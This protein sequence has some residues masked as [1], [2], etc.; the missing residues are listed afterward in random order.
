MNILDIRFSNSQSIGKG[1]APCWAERYGLDEGDALRL[2]R[3][4]I[5]R[6]SPRGLRGVELL[7]FCRDVIALG[8][9]TYDD[10]ERSVDFH[11]AVAISLRERSTR[12]PRTQEELRLVTS[13]MLNS[14]L[15][16][17]KLRHIS[18]SDCLGVLRELFATPHQF[19]KGRAILHS[20]FACGIKHGWCSANPVDAIL[21]PELHEVEVQPLPWEQLLSLLRMAQ[22]P[23]HLPCMPALG[24]MLWAGVRP[25]EVLRLDWA[26]LDWE[27]SVISL[28]PR[29]TKTGGSRHITMHPALRT[30]LAR[31]ATPPPT[32]GNICPPDWC[33]RW[34]RL[35]RDAGILN[36]QQDTLRHTFASYHLK[37][38]HD[39]GRLQEEMGHRSSRLL[40]TRYLSMQG[41]TRAHAAL[42]WSASF[43]RQ[44][45]SVHGRSHD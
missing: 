33:H 43:L 32:A 29:H 22:K 1:N 12:R 30:W 21:R 26:D 9:Q 44:L 37:H 42:F 17:R 3:E 24:I 31:F 27:E 2:G 13:R 10:S 5:E 45:T 41:V 25:A 14:R 28:R 7:N 39:M 35:R 4:L 16:C 38:W 20:I 8:N 6:S 19:V 40:R 23:R 36:W 15:A 18:S 34:Q 11:E